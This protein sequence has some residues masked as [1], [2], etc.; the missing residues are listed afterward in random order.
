MGIAAPQIPVGGWAVHH[1]FKS[2]VTVPSLL[3]DCYQISKFNRVNPHPL[4][5][6]FKLKWCA[7]P[8]NKR[9]ISKE[10]LRL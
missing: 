3:G 5:L 9:Y 4:N 2:S 8:T 6:V 1:P 10:N 7:E